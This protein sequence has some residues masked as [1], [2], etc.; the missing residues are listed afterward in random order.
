MSSHTHVL[1]A[2]RITSLAAA[3]ALAGAVI[4]CDS[5]P[6]RPT[7]TPSTPGTPVSPVRLEI[8][9]PRSVPP[10]ATAQFSAIAFMADG[11][12][13]DVSTGTSWQPT[14][15]S[16][17][18]VQGGLV[19]GLA[20][21]Q[22]TILAVFNNLRSTKEVI[23]VPAGTV[24]LTGSVSEADAANVPV[25]NARVEVVSGQ[26]GGLSVATANDGERCR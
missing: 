26:G 7:S 14:Q 13:R 23:V 25:V 8:Q 5:N 24:R 11:T 15:N 17:L 6:T 20:V 1:R 3:L 9:G 10:G 12:S 22:V 19:R 4:A 16:I 2:I 21:G 18:T